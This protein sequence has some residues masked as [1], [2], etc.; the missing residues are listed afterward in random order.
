MPSTRRA[1]APLSSSATFTVVMAGGL[2]TRLGPL[3]RR[4]SKPA[5]P[6]GGHYRNI[7]FTLSNC[8]NS[9]LRRIALLTQYNAH[10][11]IQHV[12]HG[13]SFLPA[14]AGEFVQVWPAQQRP[15]GGW[16]CG[17]A[18]AVFQNL[19]LIA[20]QAPRR[21]LV[22]AGDHVYR[23]NYAAMLEAHAAS[24]AA[25]TIGCIQVPIEEASSFGVMS[26]DEEGWITRFDEKP[27]HPAPLPH[28]RGAALVSMGIYV[29]DYACLAERLAEDAAD[30]ASGHDFGNDVLPKLIRDARVLAYAMPAFRPGVDPYWRDVG[31]IEG[32]WRTNL[33]LL[34][35]APAIDLH[36]ESWP[37]W[38]HRTQCPPAR[39]VGRGVAPR[40]IVAG[41]CV[42][43]GRVENSVL[44]TR[45][46]IGEEASIEDA[47][48]LAN[49]V[50][51]RGSRLRRVVVEEGCIVPDGTVIG[52]DRRRDAECFDV[53]PGGVTVVTEAGLAR[54]AAADSPQSGARRGCNTDGSG[55]WRESRSSS[56]R[57]RATG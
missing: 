3:T 11:L 40:S 39:F 27:A 37:I 15:G 19:Q 48:L 21:V 52:E 47:V 34:E 9:G 43:A 44:G 30:A 53:T 42:V 22:L 49:V 41:G 26:I 46:R 1:N 29:F 56:E 32:Y 55:S 12:Q 51:G 18:D 6:F 25:A 5:L 16:Y 14:E 2:G 7:D 50:V 54:A 17:T 20:E 13:W 33:D 35:H 8:I 38:T 31:T 28:D 4:H 45:C 23:M 24:G 57:M 36:D 10:S